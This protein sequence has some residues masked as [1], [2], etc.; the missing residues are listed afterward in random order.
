[1]NMEDKLVTVGEFMSGPEAEIAKVQ[2]EA[3]GID[4]IVVLGH[5]FACRGCKAELQ[6][7]EKYAQKAVQIIA[8]AE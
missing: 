1:M 7:F 2:L 8:A 5:G 4:A 6:V 3:K